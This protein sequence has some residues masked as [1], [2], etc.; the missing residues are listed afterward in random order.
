[1]GAGARAAVAK[2]APLRWL[3]VFSCAMADLTAFFGQK[4]LEGAKAARGQR[5]VYDSRQFRAGPKEAQNQRA[6]C[7]W[8]GSDSIWP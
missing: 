7:S 8:E 6:L 5:R 4:L 2:A 3:L 1:M